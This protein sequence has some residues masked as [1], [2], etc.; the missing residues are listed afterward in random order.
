MKYGNISLILLLSITILFEAQLPAVAQDD[1]ELMEEFQQQNRSRR[2]RQMQI[3]LLM[4]ILGNP[5]IAKEL[6]IAPNQVEK[7][8]ETGEEFQRLHMQFRL[9]NQ[10]RQ[11]EIQSFFR[12]QKVAEAVALSRKMYAEFDDTTKRMMTEVDSLLL[13]HQTKRLKQLSNQQQLKY[14]THFKDEFGIPL[15]L[16]EELELSDEER[17]NLLAKIEKVRKEYYEKTEKLKHEANQDILKSLPPQKQEKLKEL[18]GDYYDYDKQR[19]KVAADRYKA[20][21]ERQKQRERERELQR[22]RQSN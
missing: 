3:S 5:D 9:D 22:E 7:I 17:A 12:E 1:I 6:S 16:A 19:R 13:P 11:Q 18:I 10:Q 8:R 20:D 14:T 2:D 15:A 21:R 4:Q